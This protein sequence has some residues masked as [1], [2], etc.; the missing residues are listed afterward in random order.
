MGPKFFE[1]GYGRRFFDKQLPDL[2]AALEAIA[3]ELAA[4]NEARQQ[5]LSRELR[6][7]AGPRV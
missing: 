1:T 4:A 3:R 7:K 2:I 5:Q 6:A